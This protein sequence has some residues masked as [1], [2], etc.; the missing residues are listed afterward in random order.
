MRRSDWPYVLLTIAIFAVSSG[1]FYAMGKR[2]GVV[3]AP[4]PPEPLVVIPLDEEADALREEVVRYK[5]DLVRLQA[6][7]DELAR[8][9]ESLQRT[10]AILKE[11]VAMLGQQKDEA[12]RFYSQEAERSAKLSGTVNDLEAAVD[13]LKNDLAVRDESISALEERLMSELPS[14]PELGPIAARQEPGEEPEP[15]LDPS[16]A[17]DANGEQEGAVSL[18]L[19]QGLE[20]YKDGRYQD[21]FAVWLPLAKQGVRRAQFYVGGLYNEG[22]GVASDRVAAHYWLTLS[23][24]AGY[25]RSAELLRRVTQSMTEEELEASRKLLESRTP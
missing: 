6:E 5:G 14:Q 4:A 24:R 10:T 3:D 18:T 16:S 22:R 15:K 23:D 2:N 11:S 12:Q 20:A 17:S 19:N 21:A 7:N 9:V 25:H 13:R 8:Q 1:L